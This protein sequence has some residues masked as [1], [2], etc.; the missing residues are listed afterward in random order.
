MRCL[1]LSDLKRDDEIYKQVTSSRIDSSCD[2]SSATIYVDKE[3][4]ESIGI[5]LDAK[6]RLRAVV[7][8]S[9]AERKGLKNY[10]MWTVQ[11]V[12]GF[13]L[14]SPKQ[15]SQLQSCYRVE[16][17]LGKEQLNLIDSQKPSSCHQSEQLDNT[18]VAS[19]SSSSF[20]YT[21]TSSH[22]VS[23]MG[24][25]PLPLLPLPIARQP[26]SFRINVTRYKSSPSTV[27]SHNSL[28]LG[29]LPKP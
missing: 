5:V 9:P 11:S 24:R 27:T 26:S 21:T 18:S 16:I 28:L 22:K 23:S 7:S 20:S 13:H 10:L 12:D 29:L 17:V 8:D 25:A 14:T 2:D 19:S 4:T 1:S 15:L 6:C 3:L